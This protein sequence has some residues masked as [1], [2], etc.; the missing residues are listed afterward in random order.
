M[1]NVF[2]SCLKGFKLKKMVVELKTTQPVEPDEESV[3]LDEEPI[4]LFNSIGQ[5]VQKPSL[6]SRML[7]QPVKVQPQLV[8]FQS[9]RQSKGSQGP[10]TTCHTLNA[11][12]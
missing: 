9:R 4:D 11:N 10:T 7:V 6:F 1:S 3:E 8:E 2:Q 12:D 5:G